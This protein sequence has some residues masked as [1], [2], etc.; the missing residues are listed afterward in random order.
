MEYQ[1]K[2]NHMNILSTQSVFY[3]SQYVALV[4]TLA[5]N[6]ADV[7]AHYTPILTHC[8]RNNLATILQTMFSNAFSWMKMCEFC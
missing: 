2:H 4:Y 6:H 8:G 7:V 5:Y 3:F 1:P